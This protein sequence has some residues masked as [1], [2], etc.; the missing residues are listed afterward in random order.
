MSCP[1]VAV[2]M[3]TLKK[4]REKKCGRGRGAQGAL[5]QCRWEC[6]SVQPP[7]KTARRLLA[8]LKIEGAQ[9]VAVPPVGTC[10]KDTTSQAQ[11]DGR[12]PGSGRHHSPWPRHGN[13][14]RVP[15]APRGEK[16]T[17]GTGDVTYARDVM[18]YWYFSAPRKEEPRPCDNPEGPW[19]APCWEEAGRWGQ[20]LCHLSS[21]SI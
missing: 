5:A 3:A 4:T 16:V 15:G 8:K 9:A 12:A 14:P 2:G 6:K 11:R 20:M 21:C 10:V 13:K 17:P 19:G 1:P 18:K 7:W